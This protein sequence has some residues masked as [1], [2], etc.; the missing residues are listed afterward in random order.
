MFYSKKQLC[1]AFLVSAI[2][3]HLYSQEQAVFNNSYLD[4]FLTNPAF[5]GKEFYPSMHLSVN[6]QWLSFPD[7]P[8][9]LLLTGNIRIGQFGFYNP[10]GLVYKGPL[11]MYER[12]G[13]G[14]A[15]FYDTNG[16]LSTTGG[17]LSYAYHM[18]VNSIAQL[19]LGMSVSFVHYALNSSALDPDQPEDDF[20]LTGNED[21]NKANFGFGLL[22]H[23]DRYFTGVSAQRILPDIANVNGSVEKMPNYFFIAGYNFSGISSLISY[24]PMLAIKMLGADNIIVDI[25]AKFYYNKLNWLALSYSTSKQVNFEFALRV[26]KKLYFGYKYGYSLTKIAS[27]TKGI[28]EIS[29]GINLGLIGV[30]GIRETI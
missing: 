18:P 25:H 30:K 28:H 6:K 26:Y 24:E 17:I 22:Y 4:P 23:S 20:L 9:T 15:F 7:S 8:G 13:I 21:V 5:T 19:S 10:N 27:Y 29:L 3:F 11:K 16:P 14:G 12:V 1:L 2:C